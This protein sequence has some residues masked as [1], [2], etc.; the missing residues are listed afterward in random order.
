MID[1]SYVL[2]LDEEEDEKKDEKKRDKI[3]QPWSEK[4][5]KDSK[6]WDKKIVENEREEGERDIRYKED[7]IERS[8][9][10]EPELNREEEVEEKIERD[11]STNLLRGNRLKCDIKEC[12]RM[13]NDNKIT[14]FLPV[15]MIFKL[16]SIGKLNFQDMSCSV[17]YTLVLKINVKGLI[18]EG[19]HDL[20]KFVGEKIKYRIDN[21]DASNTSSARYF[22]DIGTI[23]IV[24]RSN[25][26]MCYFYPD[27]RAVPFD[28]PELN[29]KFDITALTKTQDS[30]KEESIF[31]RKQEIRF[32][33]VY[34][35]PI[36]G[37]SGMI[38]FID[39][40]DRIPE[41]DI[42]YKLSSI[43]RPAEPKV[44]DPKKPEENF[45]SYPTTVINLKFYRQ[46]EYLIWTVVFPLFLLNMFT[47]SSFGVGD[48]GTKLSILV[49]G[50]LALF[51]FTFTLRDK[52]PSVPYLTGLEKQILLT[53]IILFLAGL[54]LILSYFIHN[55][56]TGLNILRNTIIGIDITLY[57]TYS[58][59]F[60]VHYAIYKHRI[61]QYD[62]D[63]E[64]FLRSER[65]GGFLEDNSWSEIRSLGPVRVRNGPTP[66]LKYKL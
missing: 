44:T 6:L 2:L 32:N 1:D 33:C 23:A 30:S 26:E 38:W 40:M 5:K 42:A 28:E 14:Y 47:L 56:E 21:R 20:I 64:I 46:P 54:E 60:V 43:S 39:K 31:T 63:N 37:S 16:K 9:S 36:I 15:L 57:I 59:Y 25:E 11:K 58:I 65:K 10:Y 48:V 51:A 27:L 8:Y 12:Q 34:K 62:R 19:E 13:V 7:N 52:I 45:V 24:F 50:L 41:Y 3:I 4:E 66:T 35:K 55:K 49:T 29:L 22:K 61:R 53:S 17:I 18:D